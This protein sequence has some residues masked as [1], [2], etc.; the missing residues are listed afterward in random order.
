VPAR[1]RAPDPPARL[2]S[3]LRARVARPSR[4]EGAG[5][6][7]PSSRRSAWIA[8]TIWSELTTRP[9]AAAS[10]A[11]GSAH[12]AVRSGSWSATWSSGSNA[13]VL[14]GCRVARDALVEGE[15]FRLGLEAARVLQVTRPSTLRAACPIGPN[16]LHGGV[17]GEHFAS[18]ARRT[19]APDRGS[20]PLAARTYG[21]L[22]PNLVGRAFAI[23]FPPPAL[24][25]RGSGLRASS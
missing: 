5:G 6:L 7:V 24:S 1:H 13:R 3:T 18:S 10:P 19:W 20:P 15:R 25:F 4:W 16:A 14:A 2:A 21:A 12:L 8:W 17:T 22:A 23:R 11:F 9:R